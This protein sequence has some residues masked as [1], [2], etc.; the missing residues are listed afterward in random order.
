MKRFFSLFPA[1][2]AS[3]WATSAGAAAYHPHAPPSRRDLLQKVAFAAAGGGALAALFPADRARAAAAA[4]ADCPPRSGNCIRTTWR[5]PAGTGNVAAKLA[6]VVEEYPQEGQGGVDLGGWNVAEGDI[7]SGRARLEFRSG[8]GK[9]A[10]FFNQGR[11]FVDD[12]ELEVVEGD[13][14]VQVRSSS[15]IGESDFD[16]NRKRLAFLANRLRAAGWDAPEPSY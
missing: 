15:R 2:A 9:F 11:P 7:R 5:A 6:A 10:K 14:T 3:C 13:G 8:I 16:V 1:A 12:V 4:I